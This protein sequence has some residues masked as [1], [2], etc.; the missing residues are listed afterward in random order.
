MAVQS[1]TSKRHIAPV[2]KHYY[3]KGI[4]ILF[5]IEDAFC[6]GFPN[7]PNAGLVPLRPKYQNRSFYG[8]LEEVRLNCYAGYRQEGS[9]MFTCETNGKWRS[10]NPLKC[11]GMFIRLCLLLLINR[12]FSWASSHALSNEV[13]PQ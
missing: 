5:V 3:L 1:S 8:C 9:N 7:V 12:S 2:R 11:K 13:N 4:L 6:E 10:N